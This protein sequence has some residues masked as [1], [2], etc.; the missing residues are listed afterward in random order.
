[1]R[2]SSVSCLPVHTDTGTQFEK[3][4]SPRGEPLTIRVEESLGLRRNRFT[5]PQEE[6]TTRIFEPIIKDVVCLVREQI[7]MAGE[8]VAAVVLAGGFGQSRYLKSKVREAIPDGINVVQPENRWIAVK[9]A[10][11]HGLGH[12]QP[13]LAEVE[14]ASRVARQSYGTCLGRRHA[15]SAAASD[16]RRS[17]KWSSPRCVGS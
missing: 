9:G 5:I 6:M 10:A 4:F 16:L 3:D 13:A 8:D 7:A 17:K 11:I 2:V 1:M 15:D 14:V 12:L